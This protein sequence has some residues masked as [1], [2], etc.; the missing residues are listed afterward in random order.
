MIPNENVKSLKVKTKFILK[1]GSIN[2]NIEINEKNVVDFVHN[3]LYMDLAIQ[4]T[5]K[6]KTARKIQ[7]MI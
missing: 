7:C 6:D 4:T 1:A 3:T 2:D 5:S